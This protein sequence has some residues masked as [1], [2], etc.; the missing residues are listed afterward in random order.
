MANCHGSLLPS[1]E[2]SGGEL[3]I[4]LGEDFLLVT[5]QHRR[6][7]HIT[8]RAVQA[9]VVVMIDKVGHDS[10]GVAQCQRCPRANA[11]GFDRAMKA[12]KLTV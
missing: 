3:C 10:A 2:A 7:R 1:T 4:T 12:F 5:G 9:N 8:Q 11:V 6:R